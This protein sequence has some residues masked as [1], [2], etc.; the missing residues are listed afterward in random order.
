MEGTL[1]TVSKRNWTKNGKTGSCWQVS[2]SDGGKRYKKAG[3]VTKREAEAF[4]TD[5][6]HGKLTGAARP[7]SHKMRVADLYAI[8]FEHIKR[9]EERGVIGHGY[10]VNIESQF[11]N[12]ICR[13]P[14][15]RLRSAGARLSGRS[16]TRP[17]DRS[18]HF[19]GSLAY[20]RLIDVRPSTL[21][22]FRDKL[23]EIGLSTKTVRSIML[24]VHAMFKWALKHDLIGSNPAIQI[25]IETPTD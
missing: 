4:L 2:W 8:Y 19:D 3:F 23:F 9:R 25:K 16:A 1:G 10:V 14:D 11:Y 6:E 22:N 24:N 5:R 18:Q 7:N 20:M 17:Q 12:Y 15:W 21:E 13:T